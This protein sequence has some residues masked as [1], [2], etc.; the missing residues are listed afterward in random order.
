MGNLARVLFVLVYSSVFWIKPWDT[1]LQYR[2]WIVMH[3]NIR[4]NCH[5]KLE[6]WFVGRY[7]ILLDLA[8]LAETA[9]VL[10]SNESRFVLKLN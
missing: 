1:W 5:L 4:I 7:D 2:R 9:L 3:G 10:R 6:T 8:I